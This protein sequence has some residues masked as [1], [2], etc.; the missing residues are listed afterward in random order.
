MLDHSMLIVTGA[1]NAGTVQ[2]GERLSIITGLIGDEINTTVLREGNKLRDR[3]GIGKFYREQKVIAGDV[4]G[5]SEISAGT[6]TLRKEP[7]AP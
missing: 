7:P 2:I 3:K 5:L 6:W 1:I 4:V